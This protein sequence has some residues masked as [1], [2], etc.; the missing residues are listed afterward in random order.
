M[1]WLLPQVTEPAH[2]DPQPMMGL[3]ARGG[4]RDKGELVV[5]ETGLGW[6]RNRNAVG[7]GRRNRISELG[8]S[9]CRG[10]SRSGRLGETWMVG[11]EGADLEGGE[12]P[13]SSTESINQF[14]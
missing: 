6:E 2:P 1:L 5:A 12:N 14:L 11:K 9:R 10:D 7:R 13:W 4:T 3:Q 8:A